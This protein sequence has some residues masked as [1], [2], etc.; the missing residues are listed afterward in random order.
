MQDLLEA[1]RVSLER[2]NERGFIS[3]E[4]REKSFERDWRIHRRQPVLSALFRR[5]HHNLA[6]FLDSLSVF[7]LGQ[8]NDCSI[9]NQRNNPAYTKFRRLLNDEFHVLPFR[10]RLGEGNRTPEGT[11]LRYLDQRKSSLRRAKILDLSNRFR[12]FPIENDYPCS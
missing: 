11:G 10:N 2:G 5:L 7:A 8:L 4:F 1:S 9:R 6:P 3:I 12:P